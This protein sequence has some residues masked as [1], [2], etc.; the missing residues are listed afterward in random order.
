VTLGAP[1]S[2]GDLEEIGP[3]FVVLATGARPDGLSACDV[4][5]GGSIVSSVDA[6][7][8][9]VADDV[10]VYDGTGTTEAAL[11]A[12]ALAERGQRVTFVTW[13]ETVAPWAG[14][15]HR[16]EIGRIMRR[17]MSRVITDVRVTRLDPKRATIL[18]HDGT[19]SE[20]LQFGTFVAV[21]PRLPNL[22]LVEHLRRRAIPF[23]L[24]GDALAPRTAL[25]AFK[26]G[27]EAVLAI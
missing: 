18:D 13:F 6:L 15:L 7:V 22:E 27:E 10:L 11:V 16:Y 4:T 19:G 8:H 17:Q 5:G 12:E 24:A 9:E 2:D 20:Q 26:E 21:T 3:D 23:R 25:Q 1:V 14:P